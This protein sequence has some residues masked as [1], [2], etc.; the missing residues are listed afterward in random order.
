VITL[1]DPTLKATVLDMLSEPER[2][3]VATAADEVMESAEQRG[4]E[5]EAATRLLLPLVFCWSLLV[6]RGALDADADPA[7][8]LMELFLRGFQLAHDHVG[9]AVHGPSSPIHAGGRWLRG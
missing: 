9:V 4:V 1:A 5:L 8:P 6:D 7:V 3:R 2:A